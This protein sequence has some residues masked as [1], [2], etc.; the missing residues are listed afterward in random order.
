MAELNPPTCA[1]SSLP[2]FTDPDVR[3]Q[4]LGPRLPMDPPL[5]QRNKA[6]LE[7]SYCRRPCWWRVLR[8]HWYIS[9]VTSSVGTATSPA[10]TCLNS[11]VPR[12]NVSWYRDTWSSHTF[13]SSDNSSSQD[14]TLCLGRPN[15]TSTDTLPGH[16]LLA[17]ST[18]SRA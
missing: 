18:V 13:N 6:P 10:S 5:P 3:L 1:M 15:M 17:S 14:A 9:A 7:T 11:W 4:G 16:S 12:S 8:A 2:D